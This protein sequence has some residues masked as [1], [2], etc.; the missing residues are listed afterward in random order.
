MNHPKYGLGKA[1]AKEGAGP[2]ERITFDFG[3]NVGRMTFMTL[4]GLPGEKL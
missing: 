3:S 1:V 4:G 2:T